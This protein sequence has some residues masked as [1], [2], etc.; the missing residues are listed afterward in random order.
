[1]SH[2]PPEKKVKTLYSPAWSSNANAQYFQYQHQVIRPVF[3]ENLCNAEK[4][5]V[6]EIQ[7]ADRKLVQNLSCPGHIPT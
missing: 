5:E 4:D 2:K 3:A 6:V 1:M 7:N